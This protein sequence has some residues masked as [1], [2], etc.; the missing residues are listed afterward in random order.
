MFKKNS[1]DKFVELFKN[2]PLIDW[3]KFNAGTLKDSGNYVLKIV[4]LTVRS[5]LPEIIKPCPIG[6]LT[7]EKNT[8]IDKNTISLLPNGVYRMSTLWTN[9]NGSVI[10]DYS[11]VIEMF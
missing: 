10:F 6:P 1:N 9:E 3:C 2:L 11:T 7:I 8:T 5:K 4:L